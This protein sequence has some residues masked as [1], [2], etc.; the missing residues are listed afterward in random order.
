LI[1]PTTHVS[2]EERGQPT[3]RPYSSSVSNATISS[4]KMQKTRNLKE[5]YEHTI[6][7]YLDA[8]YAFVSYH[9]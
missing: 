9:P 1:T 8:L 6:P 3:R 2:T 4:L 5:I 7:L